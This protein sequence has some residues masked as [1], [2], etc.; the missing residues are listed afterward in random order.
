MAVSGTT[1]SSVHRGLYTSPKSGFCPFPSLG[2]AAP[3]RYA[4]AKQR[5]AHRS[6]KQRTSPHQRWLTVKLQAAGD[7]ALPGP[8][9]PAEDVVLPEAGL[10]NPS[11]LNSEYDREIVGLALPALGSILVD[12][13]LSLVDTGQTSAPAEENASSK[14]M[15][16]LVLL[17][18]LS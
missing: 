14:L 15:F 10:L 11:I 17:C 6:V 12:P 3:R 9:G 2:L 13:M 1:L 18:L 16:M 4:F 7:I 8:A 5:P